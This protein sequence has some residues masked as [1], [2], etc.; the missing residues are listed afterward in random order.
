MAY[1]TQKTPL[2]RIDE[3]GAQTNQ[4]II[5]DGNKLA[6][7]D[8]TTGQAAAGFQTKHTITATQTVSTNQQYQVFGTLDIKDGGTITLAPSGDLVLDAPDDPNKGAGWTRTSDTQTIA[9]DHAVETGNIT[10]TGTISAQGNVYGN[11]RTMTNP[12][13]VLQVVQNVVAASTTSG[14]QSDAATDYFVT[15]TPSS[16]S[17]KI[18]VSF[19]G[20]IECNDDEI[21]FIVKRSIGGAS[22]TSTASTE[23]YTGVANRAGYYS[24]HNLACQ[25]LDSPNTTSAVIYKIYVT[26]A[27][28]ILYIGRDQNANYDADTQCTAMEIAG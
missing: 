15:I 28:G 7:T 1:S 16:T 24:S 8:I 14:A 11:A 21:G 26:T 5:W 23:T 10:A 9:T 3:T 25:I 19:T 2:T 18:L 13:L 20:T 6:W 17:S 27:S 12:G 22:Y 4:G